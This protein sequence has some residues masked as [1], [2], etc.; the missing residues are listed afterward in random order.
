MHRRKF[1]LDAFR[2]RGYECQIFGQ[3]SYNGVAIASRAVAVPQKGYDSEDQALHSRLIATAVSGINIVNV[4]VPNGQMVGS[5]KYGFKL[6]WM[7]R[8]REFFDTDYSKA[9]R[10]CYV[11][12]STSRLKKEMY[13]TRDCGRDGSFL[14]SRNGQR[15]K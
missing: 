5:E 13:M 9:I 1:P 6:D 7:R 12:T 10:S 3:Q 14:V 15:C 2:E 11:V 4:Y 8:L